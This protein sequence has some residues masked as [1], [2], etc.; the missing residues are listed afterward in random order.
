MLLLFLPLRSDEQ[1]VE[2][3]DKSSQTMIIEGGKPPPVAGA[4]LGNQFSHFV[5]RSYK[6][7]TRI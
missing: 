7:K 5:L 2:S 6:E 3:G 1:E 4:G